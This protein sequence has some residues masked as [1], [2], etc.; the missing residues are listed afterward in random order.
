MKGLTAVNKMATFPLLLRVTAADSFF[1]FHSN[2]D[3]FRRSQPDWKRVAEMF[4]CQQKGQR[5]LDFITSMQ[6]EAENVSL[7]EQLFQAVE[8][9]L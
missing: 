8:G 2:E 4:Q 6:K 3:R 1:A 9:G 7:D 5:V